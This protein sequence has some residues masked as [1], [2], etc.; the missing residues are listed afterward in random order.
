MQQRPTRS[1]PVTHGER[2][3]G[4]TRPRHQEPSDPV[5]SAGTARAVK[6]TVRV[7]NLARAALFYRD[8]IGLDVQR[9]SEESACAASWLTLLQPTHFNDRVAPHPRNMLLTITVP[10][11]EDVTKRAKAA[12]IEII[13][14]DDRPSHEH[15]RLRDP[16]GHDLMITQDWTARV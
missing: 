8:V 3:G 16:D 13:C 14:I 15:L 12:E 11:V 5:R 4:E 6:I 9:V 7:A 10:S 2:T 1:S